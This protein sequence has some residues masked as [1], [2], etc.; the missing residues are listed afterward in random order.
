VFLTGVSKFSKVSL[1]SDLNNLTDIS[2]AAPFATALGYTHNEVERYFSPGIQALANQEG[3]CYDDALG[4]LKTWYDGYRFEESSESVYNP[5]SVMNCLSSLKFSNFWFETGTPT[6]LL[7]LM[8]NQEYDIAALLQEPV[9]ELSFAAYDVDC[10]SI[11]PLLFQTGY[12]TIKEC[13]RAGDTRLY[14]LGF[15]NREIEQ[16]FGAYLIDSYT[17]LDKERVGVQ[18]LHLS[19]YLNSGDLHG[20]FSTLHSFFAGVPH[21]ITIRH[22]K[23]YQTILFITLRLLGLQLEAE[24]STSRGRVDAVL[25][26]P[27]KIFIIEFK[28]HGTAEEALEQVR[29]KGYP[30]A[31]HNDGREIVSVGVVFD[32]VTRNIGEWVTG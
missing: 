27:S 32:P 17:H 2:M 29:M 25:K 15:P 22:E 7:D 28:L 26:T 19:R 4:Y 6:F 20:F 30:E 11:T 21:T 18:L 9:T 5:V 8:R 12:L 16:A 13:E 3:V 14:Q 23:Y 31:W 10:I 24:V 1:F